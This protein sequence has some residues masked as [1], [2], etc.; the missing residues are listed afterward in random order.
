MVCDGIKRERELLMGLRDQADLVIDTS[1]HTVHTLKA[2]V[3]EHFGEKSV[4]GL[5]I[6]VL[7]FGFKYGLPPECD[8]VFD[9]RFL[10]NPY[11]VEGMRE[12]TGLQTDVRDYVLGAPET[13]TVLQL[14]RQVGETLL[15]LYEREGK[16]YLTVG[17][18]CTGG[19]HRS[20]AL[21]EAIA[22]RWRGRGWN[23]QTRHRDVERK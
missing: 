23:V 9:V 11:F 21:T 3:G 17:I 13:A 20:V 2:L 6:T 19:K 12:K 18:G 5:Q 4:I 8:L 1:T 15:P 10:P 22:A 7:S 16:A 14:L